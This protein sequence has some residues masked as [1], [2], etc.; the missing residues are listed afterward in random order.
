MAI[1]HFLALD[2]PDTGCETVLKISDS[3]TY[4]VGL[5]KDC[6]RLDIYLPGFATPVY[7][8]DLNPLFNLNLSTIDFGLQTVDTDVLQ[9]L[10]DGLW[11]IRFSVSPNDKV[12]VEYYHLRTTRITNLYYKELCK[13][14]LSTCEPDS[15]TH[16]KLHDL[17]YIKMYI[18]GAKSKAEYCH[19][20]NQAVEMLAYAEKLLKKY[21]SGNC[22][23]TCK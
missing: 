15:E 22:C 19:S 13:L 12:Y 11:K 7:I 4:G 14:R 2:V 18:D 8:N 21:N 3:S 17:R 6:L 9:S 10:P 20:P 16:Q 5:L 1:K 23:L